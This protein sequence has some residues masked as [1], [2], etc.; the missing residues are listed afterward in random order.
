MDSITVDAT[1]L[2][3]D[4]LTAG[5]WV[6]LIGPG[7]EVDAL[8]AEAGTI[9]YEILTSLGRRYHRVYHGGIYHGGDR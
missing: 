8:A 3:E 5:D 4:A 2:P 1:A 9:A 7:H 6:D